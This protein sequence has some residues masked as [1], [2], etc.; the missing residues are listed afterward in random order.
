[1][2]GL[3]LL[4]SRSLGYG[5]NLEDRLKTLQCQRD[6]LS[7]IAPVDRVEKKYTQILDPETRS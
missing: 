7:T 5:K 4:T 2:D 6:L 1:M 3:A